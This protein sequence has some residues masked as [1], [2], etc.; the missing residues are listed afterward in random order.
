MRIQYHWRKF[1]V[2]RLLRRLVRRDFRRVL[3]PTTGS[4]CYWLPDGEYLQ[5][6]PYLLGSERWES[7]NMELWSIDEIKKFFRRI[8]LK[9]YL[10]S[11]SVSHS[12]PW[13]ICLL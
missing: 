8:G 10:K 7:E 11:E 5:R 12:L 3:D 9:E 4:Y 1:L 13:S 2:R 6:T